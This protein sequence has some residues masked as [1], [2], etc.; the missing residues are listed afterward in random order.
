MGFI[1]LLTR[2]LWD[3]HS[4]CVFAASRDFTQKMPNTFQALMRFDFGPYPWHSMAVWMLSQMK[5]W[6]QIRGDV[7]YAQIAEKIGMNPVWTTV[8]LLGQMSMLPE[9]A[10][11]AAKLFGLTKDEHQILCEIPYRGSLPPGPPTDPLVYRFYELIHK[12]CGDGIMSAIDFEMDMERLSDPKGDR[13][14][15][16]MHGK[17]LPY[18]RY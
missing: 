7:I 8:A 16:T 13:V 18:R 14:K 4:C 3:G 17:F 10:S 5:C 15:T 6:G 1:H 9:H 11:K 2:E 12:E